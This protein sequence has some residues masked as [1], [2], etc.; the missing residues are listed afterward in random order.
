MGWRFRRVGELDA[1][2]AAN[3]R[4]LAGY[5]HPRCLHRG[6]AANLLRIFAVSTELME[7]VRRVGDPIAVLPTLFHLLWRQALRTDLAASPLSS[8]SLIH[9]DGDGE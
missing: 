2:F 5:R 8:A 4:W 7:G 6:R 1:V 3:L 9:T